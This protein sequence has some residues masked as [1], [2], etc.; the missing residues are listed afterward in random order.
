MAGLIEMEREISRDIFVLRLRAWR[1]KLF[2][3]AMRVTDRPPLQESLLP[4][5]RTPIRALGTALGLEVLLV[6]ALVLV[7]LFLPNTLGALFHQYSVTA[8]AAHPINAWK[9]RFLEP[10]APAVSDETPIEPPSDQTPEEKPP[11]Y[12]PAPSAPVEKPVNPNETVDTPD[13]PDL[14]K[15]TPSATSPESL[16]NSAIPDLKK[17][18]EAVQIGGFG[19]PNGLSNNNRHRS[20]DIGWVGSFDLPP[21]AAKG[22]GA[23]GHR[24]TQGMVVSAGFG[25]GVGTR[26]NSPS[27]SGNVKQGVFVGGIADG[28][29][30]KLKPVAAT[31]PDSVPV[32][33]LFKPQPIYTDEARNERVEGEVLLQVIFLASGR[34][35]VERVVKG[36]GDGLDESAKVAAAQIRFRPAQQNGKPV[37]SIAIVHIDFAL[38]Y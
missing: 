23:G 19:D 34:V 17:P 38:A 1:G 24:N 16:G 26:G 14:G 8:I 27:G 15:P 10:V 6:S 4:K 30:A 9:P 20:P 21:G 37:D 12:L 11:L 35:E 13:A 36:L 18:Q 28:S 29:P 22:N 5:H 3:V 32:Q 31:M 7:P 33:I 25:D 2:E